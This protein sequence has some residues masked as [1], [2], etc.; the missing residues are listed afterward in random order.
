MPYQ[1]VIQRVKDY[2]QWKA[3]FDEHISKRKEL[4]SKG[5][6]VFRNSEKP[7]EILVLVEWGNLSKAREFMQWGDPN[8]IGK[9]A[10]L[11]DQPDQYL[12]EQ[13][14]TVVA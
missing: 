9:K 2:K 14:A 7:N 1:L 5:V 6:K 3:V 4:G 12:L 8:E 11:I 13:I 10:G